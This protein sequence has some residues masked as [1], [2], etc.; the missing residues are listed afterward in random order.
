MDDGNGIVDANDNFFQD[1][2]LSN[3]D[4]QVLRNGVPIAASLST[5]DNVE[6][7]NVDID[8]S[9]QYTIRVLG[10]TVFGGSERYAVAWFVP[11]P[12][13][14]MLAILAAIFGVGLGRFRARS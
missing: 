4:L 13:S 10:T 11:E 7:L 8:Q 12:G 6:Y 3:L 9:G 2:T 1:Q 5:V 14:A